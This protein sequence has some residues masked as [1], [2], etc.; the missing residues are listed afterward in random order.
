MQ[1]LVKEE[2]KVSQLILET[3][4]ALTAKSE[5]KHLHDSAGMLYAGEEGQD[6]LRD[7]DPSQTVYKRLGRSY[8]GS[9]HRCM[10]V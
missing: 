8:R 5:N 7:S 2:K 4:R 6:P 3:R 9:S 10:I 1:K